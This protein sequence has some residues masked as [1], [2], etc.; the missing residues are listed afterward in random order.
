MTKRIAVVFLLCAPALAAPGARAAGLLSA[1][2]AQVLDATNSPR[3]TFSNNENI[4]FSQTVFNGSLNPGRI[5]F[6]FEVFAPNGNKV[7]KQ[8]GNAVPGTVGNAAAAISGVAISGFYQGPGIYTLKAYANLG[9][10]TLEQDKTFTVS[11]PN[12]LLIYPPNGATN[13]TDNPL[14]F[15]WFSSGATSYR[16]TVADNIALYNPVYQATTPNGVSSLTY[17][18][19]PN[20]ADPRQRLSAGQIYYWKVEGLDANGNVIASSP[21]PFSFSVSNVSLTRDLAI[22]DLSAAGPADASGNI[23]FS[24][25]VKNQGSTTESNIP[26][27]LMLGGLPAPSGPITMPS[28]SPADVKTFSISA[29]I[30][31]DQNS[32]LAI[33][34]V[35]IFDDDN[36]NNC[37]TLN[38][39][40][41]P[42]VST[43]SAFALPGSGLQS[44]DQIWQAIQNL[45]QAQGV[46]LSQYQLV[47]MEGSLS[48]DELLALLD[49]LRQGTAQVSLSGPPLPPPTSGVSAPTPATGAPEAGAPPPPPA[50]DANL[51]SADEILRTLELQLRSM[52]IDLSRYQ[53]T[54]MEGS[55]TRDELLSLLEQLRQ[56][57]ATASLSGPPLAGGPTAS[58]PPGTPPAAEPEKPVAEPPTAP[59]EE[60]QEWSG[61]TRPLSPRMETLSVLDAGRWKKLWARVSDGSVPNVD[62]SRYRVVAMLAGRG[63]RADR[64][65][66]VELRR[67]GPDLLVRYKLVTY[68]RLGRP[69]APPLSDLGENYAPYLLKAIPNDV[70]R[71]RFEFVKENA[72]E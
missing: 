53:V 8:S 27:K 2:G 30:P 55:L 12:L 39:T 61:Y 26:L 33:A 59:G 13:L 49:Q 64:V 65:E 60:A 25:T 20:P 68:A 42:A 52:G 6:S 35:T 10:V 44:A 69:N 1:Q 18:N 51:Q 22:T 19:T 50:E 47:G 67:E 38:V 72:N 40:R 58:V 54:S 32:S 15:Q 3:Q 70:S 9:G 5:A 29:P 34:C 45:L 63:V 23:P 28:L 71:V 48:R 62:F 31:A 56:G 41:P 4:G 57:Q 37:R 17:P 21:V 46:D 14:T 36:S 43:G 16:V 7:F 24:V 66:V 11:S